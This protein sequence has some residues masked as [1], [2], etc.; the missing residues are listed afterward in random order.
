MEGVLDL[1][2]KL[3]SLCTSTSVL[4][5]SDIE[6]GGVSMMDFRVLSF[7]NWHVESNHSA[8]YWPFMV[9][10]LYF[11]N[12]FIITCILFICL[13]IRNAISMMIWLLLLLTRL[14]VFWGK[15]RIQ[16]LHPLFTK[17]SYW[18]IPM[19]HVSF[20]FRFCWIFVRSVILPIYHPLWITFRLLFEIM[21]YYMRFFIE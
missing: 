16:I 10:E 15:S 19:L 5:D 20:W 18:R 3:L 4:V 11:C 8:Y 9:W 12:H 6:G 1:L 13:F 2:P 21:L 17:S 7:L 14:V